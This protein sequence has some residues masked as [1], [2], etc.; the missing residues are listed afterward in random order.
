MKTVT[1][2]F[3]TRIWKHNHKGNYDASFK[4]PKSTHWWTNFFFKIDVDLFQSIIQQ[5]WLNPTT[6]SRDIVDLIFQNTMACQACLTKAKKSHMIKLYLPWIS[7]YT[8]RAMWFWQTPKG[9]CCVSFKTKKI[10]LMNHFFFQNLHCQF[11]STLFWHASLNPNKITWSNCNFYEILTTL[12]KGTL[13]L[14]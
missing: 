10:T 2:N 8:F 14:N 11:I 13:Y 9:N 6:L 4:H 1:N 7:Y 5:A 12:K 3:Q